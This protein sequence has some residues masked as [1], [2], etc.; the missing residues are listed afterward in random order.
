MKRL[1]VEHISQRP[2]PWHMLN[3]KT[4]HSLVEECG[5]VMGYFVPPLT[6]YFCSI[7]DGLAGRLNQ[8]K[9][10]AM[11]INEPPMPKSTLTGI[12]CPR[13]PARP[14]EMRLTPNIAVSITERTRPIKFC[15]SV[16]QRIGPK[17]TSIPPC[18]TLIRKD[19]KSVV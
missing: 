4:F 6:G 11:A 13:Y 16:I 3:K 5:Y 8:P 15:G 9:M 7:S 14:T 12:N 19:R 18:G 10:P 17:P 1:F 2:T